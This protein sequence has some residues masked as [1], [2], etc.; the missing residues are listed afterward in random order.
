MTTPSPQQFTMSRAMGGE[1]DRDYANAL[2][3]CNN[4]NDLRA[5]VTAYEPLARD[6]KPVVDLM[7]EADFRAFRKGLLS[8]RK[9]RFAGDEW[10]KRFGAVL[11]PLPMFRITQIAEQFKAPFGVAWQ[12]CKDLRPDLLEVEL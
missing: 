7:T 1:Q 2:G 11:M 9:G 8:E 5:L 3:A 10:A 12:R 4:L 6:A